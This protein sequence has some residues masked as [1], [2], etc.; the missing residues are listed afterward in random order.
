MDG[1]AGAKFLL[2]GDYSHCWAVFRA[3]L[4]FYR[5]FSV[6]LVKRRQLKALVAKYSTT[7]IY[8]HSIVAE[9]FLRKKRKF[10]DLNQGDFL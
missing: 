2:A 6:T 9:Y 5:T 1:L 4:S 10:S 3:H 8:N 7:A